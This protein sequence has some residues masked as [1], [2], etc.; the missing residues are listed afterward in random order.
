M[1]TITT[2]DSGERAVV[3]EEPFSINYE[4]ARCHSFADDTV[5]HSHWNGERWVRRHYCWN[6]IEAVI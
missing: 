3:I 4:C 2:F 5:P 1:Q 6:C